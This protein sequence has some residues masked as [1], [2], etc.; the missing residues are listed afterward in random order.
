MSGRAKALHVVDPDKRPHL[1]EVLRSVVDSDGVRHPV[2]GDYP[3]HQRL[4]SSKAHLGLREKKNS[5]ENVHS[6][7][8]LTGMSG[9][10]FL[11][12]HPLSSVL[13][14]QQR[15]TVSLSIRKTRL[16]VS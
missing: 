2:V 4:S 5:Q 11:K 15:L 7:G 14:R 9:L 6:E 13:Q 3:V 10:R 12:P 8:Q 1:R 16:E